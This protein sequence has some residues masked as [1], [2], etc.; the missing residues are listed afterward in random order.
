MP[1]SIPQGYDPVTLNQWLWFKHKCHECTATEFQRLFEEIAKRVRP[2]FM[3]IRPYGNIGDRKCDGL[4][5]SNGTVF[6]VY[7]PDEMKQDD[8][9]AKIDE[10]LDGAVTAWPGEFG[11]WVFVYNNRRGLPPD[12]PK[13]LNA[14]QQQYPDLTIANWSNDYLWELLR[15]LPLQ[16]RAEVLGA[17]AGYEHLF[18]GASSTPDEVQALVDDGW[19]LVVQDILRPIDLPA[20][21]EALE[22]RVPLG[23]PLHLAPVPEE[24]P[25][26]TS[27]AYQASAVGD[28]LKKAHDIRARFAVFSLAPIPLA[29]HLGFA[30][31]DAVQVCCHQFDRDMCSWRWPEISTPPA[32]D[33]GVSGLPSAPI[34]DAVEVAVVVSLS[35]TIQAQDLEGV[36]LPDGSMRVEMR[37]AEPSLTWLRS[38]AQLQAVA[39]TFRSVLQS[40]RE[41]VPNCPRLH[42]FYAG[43][44]GGAVVIGQ[45]LN[46]RMNPPMDVY[47]YDRQRRPRYARALTLGRGVGDDRP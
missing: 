41:C 38:P 29:V 2:E 31:S 16:K 30:L 26:D 40:V 44:T 3:S 32:V 20:V 10:D 1:T 37:V 17:P 39:T 22:P 18:L 7:S 5:R 12:V 14:K 42:L 23:P 19:L 8:L 33:I 21:V 27:A 24:L 35:A 9:V 45:Q 13:A 15:G 46:P 6:Q 11:T 36:G 25:W 4:L 34:A 28:F 43:P 47:E